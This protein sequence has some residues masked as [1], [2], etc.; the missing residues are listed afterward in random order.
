MTQQPNEVLF[1]SGR[2]G[3]MSDE[4]LF[5]MIQMQA[6]QLNSYAR[7]IKSFVDKFQIGSAE[8][9]IVFLKQGIEYLEKLIS[10]AKE[11][12]KA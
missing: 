6:T 9:Q 12:A 3:K 11:K 10:E 7:N 2:I 1:Q 8:S 4:I 5:Q